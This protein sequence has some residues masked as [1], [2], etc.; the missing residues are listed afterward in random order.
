MFHSIANLM[1]ADCK[2]PKGFSTGYLAYGFIIMCFFANF[3]LQSYIKGK[4]DN[5][6]VQEKK[7]VK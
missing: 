3:Y 1:Q 5:Q 4:S 6:A 7:K 2:F